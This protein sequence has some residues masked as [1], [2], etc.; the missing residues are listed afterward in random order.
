MMNRTK[1]GR[2]I[3]LDQG[4]LQVKYTSRTDSDVVR[5]PCPACSDH[6]HLQ[7]CT[8]LSKS[9]TILFFIWR[10]LSSPQVRDL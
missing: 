4:E 8:V 3:I 6:S 2:F 9:A 10:C 7:T 1:N 5:C